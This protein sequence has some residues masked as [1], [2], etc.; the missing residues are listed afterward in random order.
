MAVKAK[1]R[2][3]EGEALLKIEE[4]AAKGGKDKD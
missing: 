4:E 2:K 1:E 3:R